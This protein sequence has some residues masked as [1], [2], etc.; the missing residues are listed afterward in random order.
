MYNLI[1]L[2][3]LSSTVLTASIYR[4]DTSLRDTFHS[5]A[6]QRT[7]WLGIVP[8]TSTTKNV[9][10]ILSLHNLI[11]DEHSSSGGDSEVSLYMFALDWSQTQKQFSYIDTTATIKGAVETLNGVVRSIFLPVSIDISDF[12]NEF[13]R[14]DRVLTDV[15]LNRYYVIYESLGIVL[16]LGDRNLTQ[17]QY[18]DLLNPAFIRDFWSTSDFTPSVND[19]TVIAPG[20]CPIP[21]VL[22]NQTP[23]ASAGLDQTVTDN[24]DNGRERVML[25]GSGSSDSDGT[26]ESYSWQED[27]EEI[28]RGV[29]PTVD[30]AIGTHTITL[31][32]TDDDGA[33]AR[34]EV[35]IEVVR[36]S[37]S[38]TITEFMLVDA[39]GDEDLRPLAD[40]DTI[41]EET[42][43]IRVETE[44]PRVGSVVF[45]LDEEPRFKVENEDAYALKGDDNGD[46]HAWLAE[47]GTYRLTA[48]P[49]TEA[50]G[51]GE[52][53]TPLTI[54]LRVAEPGS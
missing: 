40:G 6:C 11:A 5:E 38:P 39:D 16:H 13:G 29:N 21:T 45:G 20:E 51:G 52:A 17:V 36:P 1:I 30:L 4:Q 41:T 31:V 10:N 50:D 53:G 46:Y 2:I 48:T 43:T 18:L 35:I 47:P 28:A 44:P 37:Q 19:C 9:R 27:G 12:V 33:T 34:D 22:P 3:M 23:T 7:C 24:D 15:D 14:P 42:I 49:Y 8:G 54:T 32:V 26:I 25:D